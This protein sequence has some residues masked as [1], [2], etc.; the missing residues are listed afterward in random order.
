MMKFLQNWASEENELCRSLAA[1]TNSMASSLACAKLQ[2]WKLIKFLPPQHPSRWQLT[3]NEDESER[4]V[5]RNAPRCLLLFSSESEDDG[6]PF[7]TTTTTGLQINHD[8]KSFTNFHVTS[9]TTLI[10]ARLKARRE[11]RRRL[12]MKLSKIVTRLRA[13]FRKLNLIVERTQT[14]LS[15]S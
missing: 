7:S 8:V 11:G 9:P 10:E 14:R 1:L 15:K 2:Q 5:K 12:I 4:N 6:S 3:W 13:Q